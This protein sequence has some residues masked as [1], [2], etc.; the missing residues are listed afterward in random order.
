[1]TFTK[2]HH[3]WRQVSSKSQFKTSSKNTYVQ[4]KGQYIKIKTSFAQKVILQKYRQIGVI[5]FD[6][7][8]GA[9]LTNFTMQNLFIRAPLS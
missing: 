1:M 8:L 9:F 3:E 4:Y 6:G 2:W 5:I 7:L